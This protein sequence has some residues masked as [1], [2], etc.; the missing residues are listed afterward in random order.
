[1]WPSRS[2]STEQ[3]E[4]AEQEGTLLFSSGPSMRPGLYTQVIIDQHPHVLCMHVWDL[5]RLLI[6]LVVGRWV[7]VLQAYAQLFAAHSRVLALRCNLT[8][9]CKLWRAWAH[10]IL[11]PQHIWVPHNS[12]YWCW[13]TS[14]GAPVCSHNNSAHGFEV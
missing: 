10:F 8:P 12:Q 3:S 14:A 5:T 9:I 2:R 4:L 11:R 6:P 13:C 1:M 7:I